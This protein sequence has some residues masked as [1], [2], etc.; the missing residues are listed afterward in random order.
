MTL[1]G[2]LLQQAH[3]LAVVDGRRPRQVSLRRSI[4][5]AYYFVFHL[6]TGEIASYISPSAELAPFVARSLDHNKL[7]LAA[8]W[9]ASVK[10][11]S[12]QPL[13]RALSLPIDSELSG[14]CDT[15]VALQQLRHR[16]DYDLEYRVD[17]ADCL[18]QLS[19]ASQAHL[20][21]RR[22]RTSSNAR[23]LLLHALGAL[24]ARA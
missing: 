3:A 10:P 18:M 14:F 24:K 13:D 2:D 4:S 8:V 7:R 17:R 21:W 16:A 11:T 23:A 22:Q 12:Q 6:L 1:A 9:L 5:A 20:A 15:F 19:R